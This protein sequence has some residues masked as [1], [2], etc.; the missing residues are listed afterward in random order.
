MAV[1]RNVFSWFK[2]W[3]RSTPYIAF[4]CVFLLMTQTPRLFA[5]VDEGA[6]NGT[7]QDSSGAAVPNAHVTLL[8][9]DQG[10]TLDAT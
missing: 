10:I 4:L 8:N 2:V 7:V 9:T 5:Q 6:I 3:F 1:D